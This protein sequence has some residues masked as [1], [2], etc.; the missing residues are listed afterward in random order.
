MFS[1]VMII[2]AVVIILWLTIETRALAAKIES[3]R[4]ISNLEWEL[5]NEI[6]DLREEICD[7]RRETKSNFSKLEHKITDLKFKTEGL[8]LDISLLAR[9]S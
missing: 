5:R 1:L 4:N 6:R 7:L 3:R 9:K 8:K 2:V